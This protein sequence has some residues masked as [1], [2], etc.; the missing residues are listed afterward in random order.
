M[1][2]AEVKAIHDKV[3]AAAEHLSEYG[4]DVLVMMLVEHEPDQEHAHK[5]RQ[6]IFAGRGNWWARKGMALDFI[7]R[8]GEDEDADDSLP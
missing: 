7:Q 8:M 3:E 2:Q 1:T 4:E 6:M 5:T